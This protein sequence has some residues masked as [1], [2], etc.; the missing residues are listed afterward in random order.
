[1]CNITD[2][3]DKI[4]P[5]YANGTS[6]RMLR[7]DF[8]T[9]IQTEIQAYLL[10]FYVADGSLDIK[11]NNV[12]IKLTKEDSEIIDLFQEYISPNAYTKENAQSKQMGT[13]NKEITIKKSYQ[14]DISSIILSRSLQELGYSEG[15]TYK[16]LSL[17]N[18][19]EDLIKHFIRGYFDGDG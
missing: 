1:M 7:H 8:F 19:S 18:I 2:Q 6:K 16:E 5:L 3:L 12:R 15:K 4:C 9:N 17:P 11:R 10:G 13:N 14:I